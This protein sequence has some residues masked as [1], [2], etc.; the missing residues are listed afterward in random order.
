[1]RF[2]RGRLCLKSRFRWKRVSC[3]VRVL[4]RGWLFLFRKLRRLIHTSLQ[5]GVQS[6]NQLETVLN[7]FH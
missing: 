7:G 6:E 4:F 5:R 1:M 2:G 3:L